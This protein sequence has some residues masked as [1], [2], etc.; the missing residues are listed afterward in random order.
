MANGTTHTETVR[1]TPRLGCTLP[2]PGPTITIL[3]PCRP[4]ITISL[5]EFASRKRLP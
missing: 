2:P 1:C 5:A 4:H 3:T